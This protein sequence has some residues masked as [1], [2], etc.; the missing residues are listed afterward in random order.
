MTVA[1]HTFPS[2][3][4]APHPGGESA[5]HPGLSDVG[6]TN[7]AHTSGCAV[8]L[9]AA[10]DPTAADSGASCG[11]FRASIL[12]LS[13]SFLEDKHQPFSAGYESFSNLKGDGLLVFKEES[14][15]SH[16]PPAWKRASW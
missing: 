2:E 16:L 15:R 11:M 4:A 13:L 5:G 10:A 14:V 1:F 9:L 8:S 3:N 12:S 6:F 7:P